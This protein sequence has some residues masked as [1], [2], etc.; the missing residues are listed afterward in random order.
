[1]QAP[2]TLYSRAYF[3]ELL[4][5]SDEGC[6]KKLVRRHQGEAAVLHWPTSSLRDLDLEGDYEEL[7]PKA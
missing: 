5:V 7:A 2:P 4:A 6:A 3:Q 1:M